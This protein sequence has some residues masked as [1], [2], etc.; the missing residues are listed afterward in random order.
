MLSQPHSLPSPANPTP[1]TRQHASMPVH[2]ALYSINMLT[3]KKRR[4]SKQIP[5]DLLTTATW[6]LLDRG[7]GR[8]CQF[9]D[10]II[11]AVRPEVVIVST[12]QQLLQAETEQREY[13]YVT[14]ERIGRTIC[15]AASKGS[16]GSWFDLKSWI[17]AVF[18][19]AEPPPDDIQASCL[20]NDM[21]LEQLDHILSVAPQSEGTTIPFFRKLLRVSLRLF[22]DHLLL[23]AQ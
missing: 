5:E 23:A 3:W 12:L 2:V 9:G 10:G 20:Y 4:K 16:P 18:L 21:K 13:A 6:S 14:L 11:N 22:A 1:S 8:P 15:H 17:Y 7:A 19:S